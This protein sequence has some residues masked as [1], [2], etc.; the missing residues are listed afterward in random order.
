VEAALRADP[1]ALPAFIGVD[2]GQQ[3]YAVVKV[4][5]VLPREAS[6]ADAAKQELQ[7]YA[8]AWGAAENVAY[9]NL[10]KERFKTQVKVTKPGERTESTPTQ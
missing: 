6:N 9:Y 5:K 10:L 8:R 7:Q 3:G 2:L 4:N 1:S